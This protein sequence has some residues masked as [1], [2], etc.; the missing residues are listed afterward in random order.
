MAALLGAALAAAPAAEATPALGIADDLAFADSRPDARAR[1]FAAARATGARVVRITLDWSLVAPGG[2]VKPAGFEPTDPADP[3]YNWGYVEDAVR[4]AARERLAV[5]LTVTQAPAW[6]EGPGRS[7]G[8][9]AGSWLPRPEELAAFSRA[10]ARRFSGF[11]PDPKQGGDGLTTPGSALPAVRR[12]QVWD[13]P[14]GGRTLLPRSRSVSHYRRM[15]GAAA[16]AVNKVDPDNV[17]IAAGTAARGGMP[18]LEFW[19]RLLCLRRGSGFATC[20]GGARFDVAAHHPVTG[21]SP[22]A[23]SRNGELGLRR[24][25]RLRQLLARA[26]RLGTVRPVRSKPLWLTRIEWST[27][28]Q[29]PGG[30]SPERQ[31]RFLA[32]SLYLADRAG[33]R[34][35][36][37][38]GLNDRATYLPESFRSVASGLYFDPDGQ[39]AKP[40]LSAYR[41]PFVVSGRVAWGLAPRRG[42]R[43]AVERLAGGSWVPAGGAR[44]G[45]SREFRVRLRAGE[46]PFRARQGTVRSRV[47]R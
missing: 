17:V 19:R 15:L 18:A 1:A 43:V 45:G 32:Q 42:R 27:P 36:V 25:G 39:T 21:R 9:Q 8:A 14:N 46:G 31:A 4:D 13:E 33:A 30:V 24:L 44:A 16:R 22:G 3:A 41:F 11:Y 6:A 5:I 34:V 29:D 38:S 47:W 10:A 12:W 26:R 28:P 40:A 2:S 23:G 7:A 35:A 37:W 20:P